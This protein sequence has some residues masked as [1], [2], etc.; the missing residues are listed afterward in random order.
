MSD[1]L[2]LLVDPHSCVAAQTKPWIISTFTGQVHSAGPAYGLLESD[3]GP[4][5]LHLTEENCAFQTLLC[6]LH[7]ETRSDLT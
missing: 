3:L 4:V 5:G 6:F 7:T 2:S 1:S